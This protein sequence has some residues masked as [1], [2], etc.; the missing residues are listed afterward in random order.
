MIKRITFI[1][2]LAALI[3]AG[4][5]GGTKITDSWSN[6]AVTPV[7]FKKMCVV[8]VGKRAENRKI[9]ELALEENLDSKGINAIGAL[10]FLPPN[11]TKDNISRDVFFRFLDV[12]KF[13]AV[14]IIS[15]LSTGTQVNSTVSVGA[16]W[17]PMYNVPFNDYYGQMAGY[18]SVPVHVST[19][20]IYYL[21]CALY[22]YPEGQMIWAAQSKTTPLA[23]F[24][25]TT[26]EY[27]ERIVNDMTKRKVLVGLK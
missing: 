11:A 8:G 9:M 2:I 20:S 17:V 22:S 4:C 3:L 6:V 5:S 7:Q 12:E 1:S 16:G 18:A 19:S 15:V 23:N 13:D 25:I 27:A 14:M 10:D 21:E 26:K 24:D